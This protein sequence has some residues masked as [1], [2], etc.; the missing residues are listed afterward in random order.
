MSRQ[1]RFDLAMRAITTAAAL[2]LLVVALAGI[3]DAISWGAAAKLAGTTAI[4]WF[5]FAI[6]AALILRPRQ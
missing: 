5:A 6:L 3:W 4:V 2:L 1:D